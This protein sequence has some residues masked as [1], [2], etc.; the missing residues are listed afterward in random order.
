MDCAGRKPAARDR[1][2]IV[3]RRPHFAH[4]DPKT[5]GRPV[6]LV[7]PLVGTVCG[8]RVMAGAGRGDVDNTLYG[9]E[10]RFARAW[11]GI[12]RGGDAMDGAANAHLGCGRPVIGFGRGVGIGRVASKIEISTVSHLNLQI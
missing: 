3:C 9:A 7:A 8:W 10:I 12:F 2:G 4:G 1:P 5:L 11:L 6:T